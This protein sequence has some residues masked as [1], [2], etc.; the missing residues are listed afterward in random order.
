MPVYCPVCGDLQPDGVT[1]CQNCGRDL[2]AHIAQ[3]VERSPGEMLSDERVA[4][5][6]TVLRYAVIPLIVVVV[7]MCGSWLACSL[8]LR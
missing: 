4:L 7:V 5:T 8:L 2:R 1:R 3:H 6:R